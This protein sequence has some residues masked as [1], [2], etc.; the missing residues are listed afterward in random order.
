M[1]EQKQ[2]VIYNGIKQ[3]L[4]D[5]LGEEEQINELSPTHLLD[6]I[7]KEEHDLQKPG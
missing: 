7:F 5:I 1:N 3:K 2:Y 4:I 6:E